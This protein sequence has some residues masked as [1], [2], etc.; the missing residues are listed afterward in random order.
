MYDVYWFVPSI[1]VHCDTLSIV[2]PLL[3]TSKQTEGTSKILLPQCAVSITHALNAMDVGFA[4][5]HENSFLE[6]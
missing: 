6:E 5:P 3:Q 1:A 4:I 2:L